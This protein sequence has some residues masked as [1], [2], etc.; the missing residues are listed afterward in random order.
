[1]SFHTLVLLIA[2]VVSFQILGAVKACMGV[3]TLIILPVTK[4]EGNAP[5]AINHTC[6]MNVEVMYY[7]PQ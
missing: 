4:S 1:M 3:F 6:K 5:R 2:E 7:E